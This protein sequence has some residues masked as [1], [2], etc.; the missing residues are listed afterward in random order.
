MTLPRAAHAV[1]SAELY[2]A[3]SYSYGRF[4]ARVRFAAG[5]GV[6]SSFFLWKEGSEQAGA[7]WNEL[8]FEKVGAECRLETNPLYG[9]P[10]VVHAQR[11]TLAL[12]LCGAFHTYAYEWT[13]EAIAWLVDGMEIRRE[14]GATAQAFADNAGA[15]GL[16]VHINLW[17]GDASF[18]G[19]FSPS[20]LP[21]HEYVDWVQYS[22]YENGAF[23]LAWREDFMGSALA[24]DWL[25]GNWASPKN[26]ST[27]VAENVNLLGGYAVLSLTT[28]DAR[29]PA[30]ATPGGAGGTDAGT[31]G[32][33]NAGGGAAGSGGNAATEAGAP[34]TP[35]GSASS[36]GASSAGSA[37]SA[38]SGGASASAGAGNSSAAAGSGGSLAGP[39]ASPPGGGA[40]T[41]TA[42]QP[43]GSSGGCNLSR[44]PAHQGWLGGL[45]LVALAGILRRRERARSRGL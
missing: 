40:G 27:N 10:A 31:A 25:T 42:N 11:H 38:P 1:S 9:N 24:T 37:G 17:P 16:S 45:A 35:G 22:S 41:N 33:S 28:D 8:D 34:T 13:P 7:F 18:G 20:I 2:T 32:S 23:K 44:R 4:E 36:A 15:K 5:D 30:G 19:N 6:V 43:S 26:L 39:G 21:V 14:T 3:K 29:G 12:D